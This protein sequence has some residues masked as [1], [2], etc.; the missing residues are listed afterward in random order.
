MPLPTG[1]EPCRHGISIEVELFY[2]SFVE[3]VMQDRQQSGAKRFLRGKHRSELQFGLI[4]PLISGLAAICLSVGATASADEPSSLVRLDALDGSAV[5]RG[6]LI[7]VSDGSYVIKTA[8]GTMRIGIDEAECIGSNCPGLD[9]FDSDFSIA[10]SISD[11]GSLLPGLLSSYAEAI[12]AVYQVNETSDRSQQI[13]IRDGKSNRLLTKVN[14]PSS[15]SFDQQA[16]GQGIRV[17][18]DDG[19]LTADGIE[20][21]LVLAFDGIGV[22]IHRDNPIAHLSVQAIAEIFSC[23][24]T[25]WLNLGGPSA[26][27]RLYAPSTN[28]STYR[29]FDRLVLEPFGVALCDNAISVPSDDD[30]ANYVANDPSGIAFVALDQEHDAKSL[31]I[32]ECNLAH[33]PSAFNIRTGDY[34][35]AGRI[36]LDAP[37][38]ATSSAALQ[39]FVDF[40]LSDN[41]QRE[42]RRLGLVDLIIDTPNVDANT[43]RLAKIEAAAL[44]A[45]DGTSI[46]RLIEDTENAKR[47]SATFR[48]QS[49]ISDLGERNAL[50]NRGQRDL[51]RLARYL[52]ETDKGQ[53]EVLVFGFA[54]ASGDYDLNLEISLQRAQS[55]ANKLAALGVA[56]SLVTGFGEE[57]PV[58]CNTTLAGRAKNRRVE[59]WLRPAGPESQPWPFKRATL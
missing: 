28:S 49:G 57:A 58:A 41:G 44:T 35:L 56:V 32:R 5:I 59:I 45:Q 50:D 34:P 54:D 42:V 48:F 55:I 10:G 22:I 43:Y 36:L 26:T 8:I 7:D 9:G 29:L 2:R 24:R 27:I 30:L 18:T 6:E 3:D 25:D 1:R 12:G 52:Q 40:T 19:N 13:S 31:A 21:E 47:L 11:V 39:R 37:T 23:S 16:D 15:N 20:N 38:L 33:E 14:L 53:S 46:T 51:S 4:R 17:F